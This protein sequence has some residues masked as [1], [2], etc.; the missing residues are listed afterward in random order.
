MTKRLMSVWDLFCR[1][2]IQVLLDTTKLNNGGIP[3]TRMSL[4][5][6]HFDLRTQYV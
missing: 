5:T 6:L 2:F 3:V 4:E 1:V